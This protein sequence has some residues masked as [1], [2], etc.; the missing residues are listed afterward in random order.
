M[1][2]TVHDAALAVIELRGMPSAARAQDA[3]QKKAAIR[4]LGNAPVSGGKM[5]FMFTGGTTLLT[6]FCR[7]EEQA[8][9]QGFGE[10]LIFATITVAS[11]SS[12]ALY[13]TFGWN[14]TNAIIALPLMV[15]VLLF[16]LPSVRRHQIRRIG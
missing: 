13:A 2:L 10:F 14:I 9:V 4:V 12:G 3:A 5:V 16:I 15:V 7:P 1:E 6:S 11:L 8:K